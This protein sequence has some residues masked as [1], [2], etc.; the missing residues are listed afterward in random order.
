[1]RNWTTLNEELEDRNA[2]LDQ[3]LNDVNNLLCSVSIPM[4]M[5]D[6]DLRIRMFTPVGG[7]A[8]GLRSSDVGR[9]ITE[10]KLDLLVDDLE[11]QV[12]EVIRSLETKEQ[13]VATQ[14]G[15]VYLMRIRPYR[16]AEDKIE[17]AVITLVDITEPGSGKTVA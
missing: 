17:G 3:A 13:V 15:N 2:E 8:L 16:S 5:L 1:M 6:R 9:P 7:E 4:V 11:G 12:A 10:L 14:Q